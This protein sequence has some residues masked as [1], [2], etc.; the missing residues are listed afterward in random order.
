MRYY[1]F[2]IQYNDTKKAENRSVPNAYDDRTKAIQK[3]HETLSGDMKN[4]TLCGSI[5]MVINSAMGIEA[6][7]SWGTSEY[8]AVVE[9]ATVEETEEATE[10]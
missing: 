10:E 3:F 9:E 4:E 2:S 5:V 6:Q 8:S 1:V 7:E